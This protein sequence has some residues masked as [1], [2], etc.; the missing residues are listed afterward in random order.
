MTAGIS[1][2]TLLRGQLAFMREHGVKVV[3]VS[4]PDDRLFAAALREGVR[5]VAIDMSREIT[6]ARDVRALVAWIRLLR[7]ERPDVVT[8]GTPKAA[9]LGAAAAFLTRVPRRVY[10]VRGLR[11]QGALG[12]SRRLLMAMERT[13][14][15]MST[16][17]V[18]V[19][20]SVG[21]SMRE[22]G[23]LGRREP[24]LLG[25]GSS[26]GVD[27]AAV[28]DACGRHTRADILNS[29]GW[30]LGTQ[31]VAFV[32]RLNRDK[33]AETLVSA[34]RVVHERHPLVALLCIGDVEEP[35]IMASLAECGVPVHLTGWTDQPWTYFSAV[36]VL[37]LP[38][39]REG[40]PNVV[41]EAASVG[42]PTVTTRATGAVDSV[43]DGVT[44]LV[45]GV[46]DVAGFSGALRVL[47]GDPGTRDRM[48]AAA[49]VRAETDFAPEVVWSGLLDLYK[50]PL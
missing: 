9:L 30:P 42:V 28:R 26:N 37:A 7:R 5:A 12:R 1:A 44:G 41:L 34:I 20:R 14:V 16:D 11:Y 35:E 36:D 38:T 31:V 2:Y 50:D 46:D 39:R 3:L 43:V 24:L 49:R 8:V 21:A 33:G 25:A 22:D 17:I 10:I 45:V 27:A 19:S 48:G 18:V 29:L 47:L 13:T 4:A 6:P 32:G 40:F 23:I 15:A